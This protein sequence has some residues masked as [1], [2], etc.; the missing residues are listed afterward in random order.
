VNGI[1]TVNNP[2]DTKEVIKLK[3]ND[4]WYVRG[5]NHALGV[6]NETVKNDSEITCNDLLLVVQAII[7]TCLPEH[8]CVYRDIETYLV[9]QNV[10][11]NK[12]TRKQ[13]KKENKL[14]EKSKRANRRSDRDRIKR[15]M[16]NKQLE[17]PCVD[18]FSS[19]DETERVQDNA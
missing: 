1:C 9:K 6:I 5:I 13:I 18:E 10:R 11:K 19:S 15:V 14:N 4:A 7:E 12:I 2:S 3:E 8:Q 17:Q 16:V